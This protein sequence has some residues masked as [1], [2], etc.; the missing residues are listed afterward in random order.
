MPQTAVRGPAAEADLDHHRGFDPVCAPRLGARR[1]LGEGRLAAGQRG[2]PPGQLEQIALLEAAAHLAGVDQP[3]I[4]VDAQQKGPQPDA[5]ARRIGETADDELLAGQ[6]LHLQ[7][8]TGAAVAVNAAGELADHALQ[9]LLAGSPEERLAAPLVVLGRVGGE[10]VARRAVGGDAVQVALIFAG[11]RDH[12][13]QTQPGHRPE[14][15]TEKTH[16]NLA[17]VTTE[18]T[19]LTWPC[20]SPRP[21]LLMSVATF[22]ASF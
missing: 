17:A 15:T 13:R 11:S 18:V 22:G 5:R 7:P 16:C 6:A 12:G 10:R 20:E 14:A 19:K 21:S 8:V 2:E 1:R 9:M 3:P 4:F